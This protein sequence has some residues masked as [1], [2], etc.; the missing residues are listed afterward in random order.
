MYSYKIVY[1]IKK[2]VVKHKMLVFP[3][4]DVVHNTSERNIVIEPWQ[5]AVGDL[6]VIE[7]CTVHSS[8]S[9]WEIRS[10]AMSLSNIREYK[11]TYDCEDFLGELLHRPTKMTQR[12]VGLSIA[13]AVLVFMMAK[14]A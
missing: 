11:F 13:F 8:M 2:L 4:G 10:R 12:K 9:E 1:V 7:D 14:R 3:S 5:N 6:T